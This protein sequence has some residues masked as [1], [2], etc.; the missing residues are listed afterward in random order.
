M[1]RRPAAKEQAG[2]VRGS[3][4]QTYVGFRR[5]RTRRRP[6]ALNLTACPLSYIKELLTVFRKY[7]PP[8]FRLPEIKK[9][10]SMRVIT[11]CLV[12][13][14]ATGCYNRLAAQDYKVAIGIR[15]STSPPTLS[16]SFSIKYFMDSTNAIEG[17]ISFGTRFGLGG[18]YERHQIIGA[19]PGFTW[20]WGVG[21]Y[22]G[23]QDSVF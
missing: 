23:F 4:T 10:S 14:I 7:M 13:L 20:F 11:L 17:L 8:A 15:F 3:Q 12:L 22:V 2:S 1:A 21:A 18:L 6:R 5:Y 19:T 16:N 9:P